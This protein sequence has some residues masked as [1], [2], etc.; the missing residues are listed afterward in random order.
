MTG[1]EYG[2]H[3]CSPG[4]RHSGGEYGRKS[5]GQDRPRSYGRMAE[6]GKT[7]EREQGREG[8]LN[9]RGHVSVKLF[10]G[11]KIWI[12]YSSPMS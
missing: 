2:V 8:L 1:A 12:S 10:M 3:A 5:P 11:D 7:G 6:E 4:P 9:K